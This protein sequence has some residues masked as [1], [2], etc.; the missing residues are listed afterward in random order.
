MEPFVG[1]LYTLPLSV[2]M[3]FTHYSEQGQ[4]MTIG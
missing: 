3:I 1:K 2:L 4:Q